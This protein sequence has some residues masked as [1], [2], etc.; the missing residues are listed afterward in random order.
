MHY[1][2]F[3]LKESVQLNIIARR[4]LKQSDCQAEYSY[5]MSF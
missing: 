4:R 2:S 3:R 1:G 5:A